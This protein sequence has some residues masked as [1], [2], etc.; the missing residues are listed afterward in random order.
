MV[1]AIQEENITVQFILDNH[2]RYS[3]MYQTT[4]R[5]SKIKLG[6]NLEHF[7]SSSSYLMSLAFRDFWNW[8]Q[9]FKIIL[10]YYWFRFP[11]SRIW[12]E[13]PSKWM[14]YVIS[15]LNLDLTLTARSFLDFWS[16]QEILDLDKMT[17]DYSTFA[18]ANSG[19]IMCIAWS[20]DAIV[21]YKAAS[22]LR[23]WWYYT[24]GQI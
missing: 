22:T 10:H 20:I 12:E 24:C 3:L 8:Q 23:S 2:F 17:E 18:V 11:S 15:V 13:F 9:L 14:T 6:A 1:S 21:L 7:Q 16:E 5:Q 19:A 4:H